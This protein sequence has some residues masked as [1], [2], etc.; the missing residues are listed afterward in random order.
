[1]KTL[2]KK[3]SSFGILKVQLVIGAVMMVAAMIVLP[4][5]IIMGDPSLLLDPYL[6]GVVLVGMLMF[7]AFAYFLFIRPY[8][9]YQKLPEVLAETDGEYLYIHGEK[10]AKI[11][12]ADLGGTIADIDL[13]FIYSSEFIAV[14]IVHLVSE[15]YGDLELDIPGYDSYKLR[16]VSNVQESANNIIAFINASLND[17]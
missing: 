4:V 3:M 7:G 13:P 2:A 12:V 11:P 6:L 1:M 10:E 16:F 5:S 17:V 15:N 9:L 14:F 8:F